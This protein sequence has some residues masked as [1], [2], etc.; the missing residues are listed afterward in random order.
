MTSPTDPHPAR[1][2]AEARLAAFAEARRLGVVLLAALPTLALA[3][4]LAAGPDH[5]LSGGCVNAGT[6][7]CIFW[8]AAKLALAGDALAVFDQQA[9]AA[10]SLNVDRGWFPFLHPP[11]TLLLFAPLGAV[12]AGLAWVAFCLVSLGA[13]ALALRLS[14]GRLWGD[15]MLAPAFLPAL[16]LGQF[17][18]IWAAG[19]AAALACLGGGRRIAAGVLIGLLTLKP[20]LGLLIPVALVAV[21]AWATIF[22]AALTALALHGGASLLFGLAYWPRMAEIYAAHGALVLDSLAGLDL[23]A[24]LPALAVRAGLSPDTALGLQGLVVLALAAAVFALWRAPHAGADRKAALL[25]AAI[26]LASPY[27]WYYDTALLALAALFL[28][29]SGQIGPGP[30]G[31]ALFLALWIGPGAM[32]WARVLWPEIAPALATL[33]TPLAVLALL[34]ALRP[35]HVLP[36]PRPAQG[37]PARRTGKEDPCPH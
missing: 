27:L 6:D 5:P 1:A 29:R 17:T 18:L 28:V 19:L 7:F 24:G 31:R 4:R 21:G 23:M 14:A 34:A 33:L 22:A 13:L 37:G 12:S 16:L 9:L 11:G 35:P 30:G 2:A 36:L 10:A 3:A 15:L 32:I 8:G 26:P 20:T 25:L